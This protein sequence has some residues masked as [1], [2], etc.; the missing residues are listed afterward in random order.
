MYVQYNPPILVNFPLEHF[1]SL[2][3]TPTSIIGLDRELRIPK[4][5]F[6]SNARPSLFNY[7]VTAKKESEKKVEKVETAVLITTAKSQA[8]QRNKE[9]EKAKEE[10]GDGMDV[11]DQ[12]PQKKDDSAEDIT[13]TSTNKDDDTATGA[14]KKTKRE[15]KAEPSFSLIPNYSRITPFQ[16][17]YVSFPPDCRYTPIRPLH[18][19]TKL[20]DVFNTSTVAPNKGKLSIFG[21]ASPAPG[22]SGRATPVHAMQ[23]HKPNLRDQLHREARSLSNSSIGVHGGILLLIDRRHTE[24]F[25]PIKTETGDAGDAN[26]Q[27]PSTSIVPAADPRAPSGSDISPED[28]AAIQRALA[29]DDD[30]EPDNKQDITGI[31]GNTDRNNGSGE[32]G[33]GGGPPAPSAR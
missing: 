10:R 14:P 33:T 7:P 19:G 4:F 1:I 17:N 12:V 6:R 20:H 11:D 9:R 27:P 13:T 25:E 18:A 2:A 26:Q 24:P 8:R 29:M 28:Q 30:D 15:R 22:A 3:F 16:L 32:G 21:S 23:M 31:H 5:D